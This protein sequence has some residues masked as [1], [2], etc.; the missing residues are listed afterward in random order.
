MVKKPTIKS[1]WRGQTGNKFRIWVV[2]TSDGKKFVHQNKENALRQYEAGV[3]VAK[4]RNQKLR[5][6]KKK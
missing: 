1:E 5:Q 6:M 4:V 3:R 2:T